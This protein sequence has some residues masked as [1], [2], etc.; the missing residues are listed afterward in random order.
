[1]IASTQLVIARQPAPRPC[2]AVALR[3][4]V[5][6]VLL[7]AALRY[8]A[9]RARASISISRRRTEGGGGLHPWLIPLR[10]PRGPAGH[11]PR[12]I[13]LRCAMPAS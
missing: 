8:L 4:P 2:R 11:M 6:R 1:M 7:A 3:Y 5:G 10:P 9:A 13:L 12:P